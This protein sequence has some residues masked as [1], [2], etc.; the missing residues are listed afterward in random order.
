[1]NDTITYAEGVTLDLT[2][3]SLHLGGCA[4]L[5]HLPDGAGVGGPV[6][7]RHA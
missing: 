3:W 4:A 6:A 2:G 7:C 5:T 1:M